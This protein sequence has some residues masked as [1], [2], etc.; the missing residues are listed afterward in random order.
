MKRCMMSSLQTRNAPSDF[1]VRPAGP[2]LIVTPWY[3]PA[4]GGV[5]RVA[6]RLRDGLSEA[7]VQTHLM[8]C[9]G[10]S[11]HSRVEQVSGENNVWR[12]GAPS[13]AFY[14]LSL[15]SVAGT[16]VRGLSAFARL[17]RFAGTH[18][19][20]AVILIYPCGYQWPFLLLRRT[21]GLCLIA[22]Y[23]GS[24][25][26][27][28]HRNTAMWRWLARR[29]LRSSD[30]V[31]VCDAAL[32]GRVQELL[33]GVPLPIWLIPNGVDVQYFCPPRI[34]RRSNGRP[35]LVHVSN[36]APTK[37]TLD[38]IEAFA[39]AALPSA[40]RLVMVG[41]GPDLPQ[42]INRVRDLGIQNRVEFVGAV[43]DVRRHLWGADLFV[44]AS[45]EE[46][47][48][49]ALLEAMACGLPWIASPCGVA[50][51]LPAGECGL[52][53]PPRSPRRLAAAMAELMSDPRRRR[54]MALRASR[55]ARSDFQEDTYVQ[56]HLE[57]IRVVQSG[58]PVPAD[59]PA[60]A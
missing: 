42:A 44:L 18:G 54:L 30:A 21:A 6:E 9:D 12:F 58:A 17:R 24:E 5:A 50:A 39:F 45:D 15:K 25:V 11:S 38:I 43:D 23:H 41:A 8:V 46:S 27:H 40:S 49:L 56:R 59:V 32:G 52:L 2:V 26:R 28:H 29:T 19:I 20:R 37:R 31:V 51:S 14:R 48:P 10:M 57:L 16:M 13:G 7:D 1:R 60:L 35:T 36:F 4:V 55:R 22:S 34:F 47:C 53:V 3:R 33:P